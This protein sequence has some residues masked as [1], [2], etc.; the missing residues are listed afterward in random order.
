M[1]IPEIVSIL[2][3]AGIEQQEAVREVKMLIEHFCDYGAKDIIM[4][5]PLDYEKLKIVEEKVK[6]RAK[7]RK[8]IQYIIGK[9]YFMGNYYKVT[10]DTLIPRDET[11][12]V[13]NHAI[14]LI[15]SNNLKTVLDIGTG[16]GCIACSIKLKTDAEVTGCDISSKAI[17]IAKINAQAHHADIKYTES[18]LFSNINESFD[19]IISNPPYIPAGTVVQREVQYEPETALF[20]SEETG[21]EFYKKIIEQSKNYLTPGGYIVFELGINE[22]DLVKSYFEDN[23]YTDIYIEKDLAGIDRVISAKLT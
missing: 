2:T 19:L 13:V 14:K 1:N 16:T 15:K 3:S 10:P 11:E 4:G 20:T 6:L 5:K 22:S 23:Q 21:C 12:I 18:D 9:A 7:T 8:P 17:E